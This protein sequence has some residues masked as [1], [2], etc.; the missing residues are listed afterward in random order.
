MN[1]E[2]G[3]VMKISDEI[4]QWCDICCDEYINADDCDELREL[5]NRI[6]RETVEL[7]R[8]KDGESIRIGDVIYDCFIN[9]DVHVEGMVFKS[10]WEI[11]TN[12]G[13]VKPHWLTH[14]IPDSFERI[15]DELDKLF[16]KLN[17][18]RNGVY[19]DKN[20]CPELREFSDRIRKL[21]A[22]ED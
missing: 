21:A 1:D 22:K 11:L 5:A 20:A 16:D 2:K 18:W 6:D 19:V 13:R 12:F 8:D 10:E 15:A 17:T 3:K 14:T 7:P 4:R 9:E